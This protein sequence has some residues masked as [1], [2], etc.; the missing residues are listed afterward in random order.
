MVQVSE[1]SSRVGE[2]EDETVLCDN[3]LLLAEEEVLRGFGGPCA[4]RDA[5]NVTCATLRHVP[6]PSISHT[7][8]GQ[9]GAKL[10]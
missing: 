9:A 3:R 8:C 7:G 6:H 4:L 10:P 1:P 5:S 2:A